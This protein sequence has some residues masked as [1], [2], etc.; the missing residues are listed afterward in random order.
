MTNEDRVLVPRVSIKLAAAKASR[1]PGQTRQPGRAAVE[2]G[3][4]RAVRPCRRWLPGGATDGVHIKS[5]NWGRAEFT[6]SILQA[7]TAT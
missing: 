3:R 6:E 2:R 1:Q 4:S 5:S 7:S